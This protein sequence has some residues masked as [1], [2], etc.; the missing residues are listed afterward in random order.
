MKRQRIAVIGAGGMARE[1]VA[2]IDRINRTSPPDSIL[3]ATSLAIYRNLGTATAGATVIG[4]FNWVERHR[5]E[6]DALAIGIGT[7]AAR[8]RSR[9]SCYEHSPI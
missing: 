4:D 7:P 3:W 6:I 9:R 5:A 8:L 1:I 2:A